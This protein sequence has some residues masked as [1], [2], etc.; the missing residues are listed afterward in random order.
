LEWEVR[1]LFQD[2]GWEVVRSA[3]SKGSAFGVPA[4]LICT[5]ETSKSQKTALLVIVQCKIQK[6]DDRER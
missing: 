4:D 6:H 2:A 1:K 5:K 3:G